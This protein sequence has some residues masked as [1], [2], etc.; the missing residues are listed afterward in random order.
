VFAHQS[1]N[2]RRRGRRFGFDEL[3]FDT[4]TASAAIAPSNR[5][6]PHTIPINLSVRERPPESSLDEELPLSLSKN[7]GV[8]GAE[9]GEAG[10]SVGNVKP[11][12]GFGGA[13]DGGGLDGAGLVGGVLGIAPEP[14]GPIVPLNRTPH[15]GQ[16]GC[17]GATGPRPSSHPH[18][19][20]D[21]TIS[22]RPG[23]KLGPP[24]PLIPEP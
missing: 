21:H 19:E 18:F 3:A 7:E 5:I 14:P 13:A 6:D 17:P 8:E 20:H 16:V 11:A 23:P 2:A 22:V 1:S 15:R 24:I 4:T 10:G 9:E 12:A